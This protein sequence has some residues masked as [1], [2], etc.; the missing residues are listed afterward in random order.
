MVE[1][2]FRLILGVVLFLSCV[3]LR[4]VFPS[5]SRE[6]VDSIVSIVCNIQAVYR[7]AAV[8]A[9]ERFHLDLGFLGAWLRVSAFGTQYVLKILLLI[10]AS[11]PYLN[12]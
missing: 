3:I 11:S 6:G 12:S 5:Y 1:T 9:R 10:K 7:R 2:W 8:G 4:F